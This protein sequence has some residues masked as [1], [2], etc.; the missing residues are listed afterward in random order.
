L[1][2][3]SC[4][5][6]LLSSSTSFKLN[7]QKVT[8]IGENWCLYEDMCEKYGRKMGAKNGGR[9]MGGEKWEAKNEGVKWGRGISMG[10]GMGIGM[11]LAWDRHGISN[12][13]GGVN[14]AKY[15]K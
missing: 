4:I 13:N 7:G 8:K 5:N 12:G 6:L 14:W 10:I 1:L 9:K 15:S 11:G 2:A 3:C